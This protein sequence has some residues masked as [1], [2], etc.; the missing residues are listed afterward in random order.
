MLYGRAATVSYS[1]AIWYSDLPMGTQEANTF[2]HHFGWDWVVVRRRPEFDA[3]WQELLSRLP[4]LGA[5]T[6]ELDEL[7]PHLLST[8]DEIRE[9][10]RL[11][12]VAKD[13]PRNLHPVPAN[14]HTSPCASSLR[15]MAGHLTSDLRKLPETNPTNLV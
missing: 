3:F 8:P 9:R 13:I 10:E 5:P 4:D 6:R 12:C 7:P 15:P 1:L 11:R 2:Y 14:P